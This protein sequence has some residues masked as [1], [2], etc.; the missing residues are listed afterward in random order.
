MDVGQFD[1]ALITVG[2][3]GWMPDLP[4]FFRIAS[5]LLGGGSRLVIYE[6]QR[7][8]EIFDPASPIPFE[9][10][11]SYF[12]Q[13]PLEESMLIA[14][15]GKGHSEGGP[16]YWF[17]HPPGGIVT[18]CVRS[19]LGIVELREYGHT[20]REPEYDIYEVRAAQLPMSY[21]LMVEKPLSTQKR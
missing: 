4:E 8:M 16:A 15:D 18:V 21:C 14:Y 12:E 17:I 19:G 11:C 20:I 13:R 3:L 1:V 2:A 5:G 9:P 10:A 6:T 7:F